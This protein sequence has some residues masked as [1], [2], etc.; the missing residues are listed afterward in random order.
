M[1]RCV[2]IA[3]PS[4]FRATLDQRAFFLPGRR[5]KVHSLLSQ[6]SHVPS[7]STLLSDDIP[8]IPVARCRSVTII[9][10]SG[11]R[12]HH[13]CQVSSH[14]LSTHPRARIPLWTASR[15][16]QPHVGCTS[17]ACPRRSARVMCT[18]VS[19]PVWV[20]ELRSCD[21]MHV[22]RTFRILEIRV[23]TT[24]LELCGGYHPRQ[25]RASL[26]WRTCE[27]DWNKR[28]GAGANLRSRLIRS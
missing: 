23:E 6:K 8:P 26:H 2:K 14:H 5:R 21:V 16:C 27:S 13:G 18:R 12:N 22:P 17:S 25:R 24:D 20:M 10:S 11:H 9:R 15:S 7:Y 1:I 19:E 28:Q 3:P 4:Q